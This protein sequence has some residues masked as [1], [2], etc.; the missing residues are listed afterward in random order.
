MAWT[1]DA[2]WRRPTRSACHALERQ[3]CPHR[4]S[5]RQCPERRGTG[6][7][8]RPSWG[9]STPSRVCRREARALG[10]AVAARSSAKTESAISCLR[11]GE[12]STIVVPVL[13]AVVTGTFSRLVVLQCLLGLLASSGFGGREGS[14]D[15]RNA[16]VPP[17]GAARLAVI[18]ATFAAERT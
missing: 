15:S 7:G 1:T 9:Y 17:T 14:S 8:Y 5:G 13:L 11:S 4:P 16:L 6:R 3:R 2:R 12:G 18:T 10:V